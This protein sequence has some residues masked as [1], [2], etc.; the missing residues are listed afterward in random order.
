MNKFITLTGGEI[1]ALSGILQNYKDALVYQLQSVTKFGDV[2][3]QNDRAVIDSLGAEIAVVAKILTKL[4]DTSGSVPAVYKEYTDNPALLDALMDFDA[5]RRERH[6]KTT[7]RSRK[8]ILNKLDSLTQRDN[9]KI[10]ILA[11]SVEKG[12]NGVFPLA[13]SGKAQGKPEKEHSYDLDGFY[14]RALNS[15]PDFK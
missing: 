1:N 6:L 10:R 5:D 3:D 11:Q 8:M 12:W 7:D 14:K 4:D 15:T 9:E 2:T 13:G